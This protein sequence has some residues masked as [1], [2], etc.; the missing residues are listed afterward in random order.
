MTY[1]EQFQAKHP[2]AVDFL[3]SAY[4]QDRDEIDL[5]A[6]EAGYRFAGYRLGFAVFTTK[7]RINRA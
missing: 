4:R 5:T 2:K 3:E 6:N 7:E 1:A